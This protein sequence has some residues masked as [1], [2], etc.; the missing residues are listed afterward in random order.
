MQDIKIT[1]AEG[2]KKGASLK[3]IGVGGA[4]GNAINRMIEE[5]LKGVEFIAANTDIQDLNSIK[6]PALTIQLGEKLTRGLAQV[7]ILKS[8]CRQLWKIP[9]RSLISSK[10]QIWSLLLQVWEEEPVQVLPR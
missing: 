8:V 7:L 4:G 3:V 2:N 10:A 1:Y 5:G 6:E 9:M